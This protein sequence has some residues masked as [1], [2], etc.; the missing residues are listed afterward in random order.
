MNSPKERP[1]KVCDSATIFIMNIKFNPVPICNECAATIT[2]QQSEW[3]ASRDR[4]RADLSEGEW[5]LWGE[6]QNSLDAEPW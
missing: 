3:W 6:I 2:I 5:M 4:L 1:C